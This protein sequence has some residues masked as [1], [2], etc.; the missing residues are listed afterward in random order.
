MLRKWRPRQCEAACVLRNLLFQ[1]LCGTGSQRQSPKDQ[2]LEP[3]A[4]DSL[5]HCESPAP[6]TSYFRSLL[7]FKHTHTPRHTHTHTH[8]H[9][10]THTGTHPYTTY[11]VHP[12]CNSPDHNSKVLL[13]GG[14][15]SFVNTISAQ[16][17]N[18]AS[19]SFSSMCLPFRF[20][21]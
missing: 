19:H 5:A 9:W 7:G 12:H 15:L 20:H 6:L 10:H 21:F 8:T 16:T 17:C 18:S 4:R 14:R 2:L 11:I 3:E 1:Q 13:Q